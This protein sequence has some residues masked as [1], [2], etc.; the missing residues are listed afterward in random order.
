MIRLLNARKNFGNQTLYDGVDV[1]IVRGERIGLLGK[2]GAGKSTLFKVLMGAE[3]LDGGE[4]RRDRKVSVGYLA[5]EIHPLTSGTVF[6]NMLDHL[7][8]WTV[9]DK[10]LKQVMEGLDK[11]D[12]KALDEYDDAMEAFLTA[13]GYEMESRAKAILLGLGFSLA[14]LEAPVATLS[15]SSKY[16]YVSVAPAAMSIA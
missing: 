16:A 9:A 2:N 7:G 1:S 4:I 14:Q 10:K 5:Q 8:P 12:P 13:G 15:T 11:G 6:E 3:H